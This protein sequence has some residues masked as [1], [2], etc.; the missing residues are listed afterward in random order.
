MITWHEC[1]IYA[2]VLI[3]CKSDAHPLVLSLVV[4]RHA[5]VPMRSIY[6]SE[7]KHV[8]IGGAYT[9]RDSSRT[10]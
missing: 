9:S 5:Q 1:P 7:H 2:L 4:V 3:F 10:M 6:L 8:Y